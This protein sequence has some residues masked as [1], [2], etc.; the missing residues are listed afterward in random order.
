MEK[1]DNARRTISN[2]SCQEIRKISNVFGFLCSNSFVL[3][4]ILIRSMHTRRQTCDI[5]FLN[6]ICSLVDI[7]AW[8]INKSSSYSFDTRN[9]Y[10]TFHII[11]H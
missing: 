3:R 4:Y 2:D 9:N 8:G 7:N 11:I 6:T 5:H 1:Q 10:S